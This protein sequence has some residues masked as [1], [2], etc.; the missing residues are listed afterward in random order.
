MLVAGHP[1]SVQDTVPR[2]ALLDPFIPVECEKKEEGGGLSLPCVGVLAP[3][4]FIFCG[5]ICTNT[6][7]L[8]C[9]RSP[10]WLHVTTPHCLSL[11]QPCKVG[12]LERVALKV[13]EDAILTNF[14]VPR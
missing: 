10:G 2:W 13:T 14:P 11:Q 7:Y 5:Y 4:N 12:Y 8:S 3:L 9:L 1:A 6:H